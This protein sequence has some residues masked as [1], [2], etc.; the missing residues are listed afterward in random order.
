[1][2]V[3]CSKCETVLT[4]E[5]IRLKE[6]TVIDDIREIYYITPCCNTKNVVAYKNDKCDDI[7]DE[8]N[9]ARRLN[10]PRDIKALTKKLKAEMDRIKELVD[11][12]GIK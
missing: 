9:I 11:C 1:M 6:N 5:D 12:N 3:V 10:K 4:E 2:I 8:I 7:Q